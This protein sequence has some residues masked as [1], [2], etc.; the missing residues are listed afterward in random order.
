[1]TEDG[2]VLRDVSSALFNNDKLMEV[3]LELDRWHRDAVQ[4]LDR[5]YLGVTTRE[6]AKSLG[7][8]DDLVKKVLARLVA[9]G[10]L[11][12][13]P[14]SGGRR[15][16]LPYEVQQGRQWRTLVDLAETFRTPIEIDISHEH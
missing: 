2:R 16:P 6:L 9:A 14:R 5:R 4:R 13:L 10:L 7:I 12:E 8:Q 3:V 11:K 15:G 1:M